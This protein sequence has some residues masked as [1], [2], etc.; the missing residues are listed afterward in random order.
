MLGTPQ[1]ARWLGA[2]L[3]VLALC[4][5]AWVMSHFTL[6]PSRFSDVPPPGAYMF[7]AWALGVPLVLIGVLLASVFVW[8]RT[9]LTVAKLSSWL[10]IS[11][12][13]PSLVFFDAVTAL[14]LLLQAVPLAL[15]ARWPEG[16]AA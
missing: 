10:L 13:V 1:I 2:A 7:I 12:G 6:D 15:L 3:G 14:L 4:R 11:F 8:W 5:V 16:K 9:S